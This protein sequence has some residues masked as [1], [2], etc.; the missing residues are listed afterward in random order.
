[1]QTFINAYLLSGVNVFMY[2]QARKDAYVFLVLSSLP[3]I[4]Q[5]LSVRNAGSLQRILDIIERY[6]RF[7]LRPSIDETMHAFI[8]IQLKF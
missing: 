7:D 5:E 4:G 8:V 3:W 1:M 6:V 2:T